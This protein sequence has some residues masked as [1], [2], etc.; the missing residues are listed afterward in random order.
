VARR[1]NLLGYVRNRYDRTVEVVAEGAEV[2]LRDLLA[3]L[4][5]GPTTSNV[6]RVD[7]KWLPASGE[8]YGFEVRF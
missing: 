2:A 4:Q 5:T 6:Q 7:V 1:L 8:F 3:F